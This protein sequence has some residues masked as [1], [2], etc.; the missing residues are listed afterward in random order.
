MARWQFLRNH[1]RGD[2][3]LTGGSIRLGRHFRPAPLICSISTWTMRFR[4]AAVAP[5]RCQTVRHRCRCEQTF[6]LGLGERVVGTGRQRVHIRPEVTTASSRSL[7]RCVASSMPSGG[8]RSMA[9]AL[10]RCRFRSN[11]AE[12]ATSSAAQLRSPPDAACSRAGTLSRPSANALGS[13]S[14]A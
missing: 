13:V 8:S 2:Q 4:V 9:S 5:G 11:S 1:S 14:C 6:A 7:Q 10:I 12:L 3:R